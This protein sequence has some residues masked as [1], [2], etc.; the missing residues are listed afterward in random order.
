MPSAKHGPSVAG[1]AI[2]YEVID[3]LAIYQGDI[4]LGPVDEVRDGLREQPLGPQVVVCENGDWLNCG[5]WEDGVVG[6]AFANDWDDPATD[7]D[8]NAVMRARIMDA[9]EH[10]RDNTGLAFEPRSGGQRVVFRNADG[11]SSALG[12]RAFTGVDPQ[13]INL[14]MG[15]G[16]G[17][18]VHEIG[19]A[20]GLWHEQSRSD[21]DA[22]VLV[23]ANKAHDGTRHNFEIQTGQGRDVGPYDYG[24]IMH[25]GCWAF[26]TT[27]ERTIT[28]LDAS[29]FCWSVPLPAGPFIGQR[30]GL[31]EGDILGVYT[32]YPPEFEIVGATPGESA[33]AF[34][35][36]LDFTTEPVSDDDIVW[37]SDR[38]SGPLGTGPTVAFGASD[39]PAGDHTVTAAVEI[40]GTTVATRTLDVVV[41][42][43]ASVVDLGPDLEVERDKAGFIAAT[44][45]DADDGA[46]PIGE[47]GYVWDPEPTENSGGGTAGYLFT[48]TG[49]R[50]IQV[51][52]TDPG[53]LT[54][55]EAV[56]VTV[57]DSPPEPSI[58]SP[59]PGT[60]L[61]V[62]GGSVEVP[63]QG[64]ATDANVGDGDGPG[65][66]PCS[67]LSWTVSGAGA[68]LQDEDGCTATLVASQPGT[69][70]V[71]LTATDDGGQEA[72]VEREVTFTACEGNC[73]PN[74]SFVVTTTPDATHEG[75]PLYYLGTKISAVASIDDADLPP[76]NPIGYTGTLNRP[77][78]P[79]D[80][81]IDSG[82]VDDPGA[83]SVS[84][85]LDFTPSTN[86]G[87]TG[88]DNCTTVPFLHTLILEVEDDAGN[89]ATYQQ[90]FY[91]ACA[92]I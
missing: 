81:E 13:H 77:F 30:D 63:L 1:Q 19:H 26:S 14:S 75:E 57:V 44:V 82:T 43:N 3:G 89:P 12:V 84:L 56:V 8:E 48:T 79:D 47:C 11:C 53:G 34:E 59:G 9:I 88:W 72:T 80:P 27:G 16:F 65:A 33:S 35:L 50:T 51:T 62:G 69:V 70:T 54:G 78:T 85:P 42:S 39:V 4:V 21:R 60:S 68:S 91:L 38:V 46:C 20:V 45:T 24:S 52:V 2:R 87:I 31:S 23:E 74:V 83:G 64:S 90:S 58:D 6:Y 7:E 17:T 36:G 28:P 40:F 18:I 76:D 71:S 10:W 5:R 49:E 25:Y 41:T 29:V 22:F 73:V 86:L 67:A 55:T 61:A 32:L 15:C 92:L 66:L 37:T